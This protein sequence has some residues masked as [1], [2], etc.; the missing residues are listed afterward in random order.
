MRL[1]KNTWADYLV[2]LVGIAFFAARA[3]HGIVA[4]EFITGTRGFP[5]TTHVGTTAVLLGIVDLFVV[6]IFVAWLLRGNRWRK[7]AWTLLFILCS[8]VALAI[9]IHQS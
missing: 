7:L 3:F 8:V 6:A 9:L 4:E 5:N 1:K 2:C